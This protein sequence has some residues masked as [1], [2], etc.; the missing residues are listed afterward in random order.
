MEYVFDFVREYLM[1]PNNW[2]PE[3][4]VARYAIIASGVIV[5]FPLAIA[6]RKFSVKSFSRWSLVTLSAV[7]IELFSVHVNPLAGI[8]GLL[9]H[10]LGNQMV[11]IGLTGGAGSG[12]S[13]LTTL[14]KKN[15]IP[16]VDADAIAKEVVAPG[17]WTLF[18]LVQSLGREILINPEDSRS[19]LDRAK[20]RGMIVSDPKAR[21][22][23]NSITH[24]MIIIEI[25]R[26]I[27]YHRVIKMRRLV[28]LDAP[29]LFETCLDRMCAP[30]ICVHVDKQTQLERLLKRDGS[31]GEDAERLQKLIDAQMDP[32]K[33]A[34]LSDY[35]LN[36][37]GSVAHFQ[38]QAVNFFAT[39]YGYT[40]RV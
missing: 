14:L 4:R 1:Q 12:K 7:G 34:A 35:R 33:R 40:L 17:S 29:L 31:K 18:F 15:N 11:V 13:T 21:K 20:L 9:S 3:N 2:L 27:F 24:P 22:T 28:V 37:G 30:I 8:A 23:V 25:F 36:N 26:Q 16:V 39:R 6:R 5:Q 38:D 19:G 32:G 10:F